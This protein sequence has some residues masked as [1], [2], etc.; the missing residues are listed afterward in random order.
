MS[1]PSQNA[2]DYANTT[3]VSLKLNNHTDADILAK[4]AEVESRQGY[5]KSLIR[6]DIKQE[7]GK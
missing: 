1:R 5:I 2:W 4:L 6:D 3:V 7:A